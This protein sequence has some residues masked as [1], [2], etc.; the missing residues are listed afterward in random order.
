[1]KDLSFEML[2]IF[3]YDMVVA[4][5]KRQLSGAL[6]LDETALG[7]AFQACWDAVKLH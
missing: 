2:S 7:T 5:A 3:A 6:A 1:M 4:L